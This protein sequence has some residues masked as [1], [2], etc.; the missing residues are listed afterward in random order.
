MSLK[1]AYSIK[2]DDFDTII[3][4][5]NAVWRIDGV[6][7]NKTRLSVNVGVYKDISMEKKIGQQTFDFQPFVGESAKNFIVQGYEYL[8]SLPEF[9]N[10]Q[11]C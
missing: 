2:S 3:T 6:V 1:K 9:K 4:A 5:A 8:K 10:A 7:G 11:D